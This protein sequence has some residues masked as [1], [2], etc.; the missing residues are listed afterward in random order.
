MRTP[1]KEYQRL[2][3]R[4]SAKQRGIIAVQR[5][6]VATEWTNILDQT[7]SFAM[8]NLAA[9]QQDGVRRCAKA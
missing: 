7:R 3:Q 4:S 1:P 8:I 6:R 9:T 5:I 2:V